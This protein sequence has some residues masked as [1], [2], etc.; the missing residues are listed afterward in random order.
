MRRGALQRPQE[1]T[2]ARVERVA[3]ERDVRHFLAGRPVSGHGR[4]WP[5]ARRQS[6]GPTGAKLA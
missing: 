2:V 1:P 6:M 4:V 5:R 3:E